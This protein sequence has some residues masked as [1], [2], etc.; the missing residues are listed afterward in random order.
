MCMQRI[1]A[2]PPP[3]RRE[4]KFEQMVLPGAG[5]ESSDIKHVAYLC[6]NCAN[7]ANVDVDYPKHEDGV[8]CIH[9]LT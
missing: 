8:V 4:E 9:L 5:G 7:T 1:R 3:R 6:L 2:P